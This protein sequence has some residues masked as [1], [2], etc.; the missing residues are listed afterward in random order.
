MTKLLFIHPDHKLIGLYQRHFTGMFSIDSAHDGLSGL[1][2]IKQVKPQVIVSEYELPF[3]S[4][5]ALLKYVREHPEMFATPF[6]FLT[7]SL[8]PENALGMGATAWLRQHEHGPEQLYRQILANYRVQHPF[9][10][11]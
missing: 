4:G 3:M 5:L 7:N 8:M 2:M 1:R 6:L 10:S 9:V 11:V